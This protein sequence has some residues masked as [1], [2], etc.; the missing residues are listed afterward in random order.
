MS[1]GNVA[2]ESK[3]VSRPITEG[4][5]PKGPMPTPQSAGRRD[6]LSRDESGRLF[7]LIEGIREA[8]ENGE[9][10][11][12]VE[13]VQQQEQHSKQDFLPPQILD[14]LRK[15]SKRNPKMQSKK[16]SGCPPPSNLWNY[17]QV[18]SKLKHLTEQPPSLSGAGKDISFLYDSHYYESEKTKETVLPDSLI[19]QEYH[20]V[21]DPGVIGL[22]IR[23]G[24]FSTTLEDKE[25]LLRVFPSSYPASRQEVLLLKN[26]LDDMLRKA[27]IQDKIEVTG[28]TQMHRLLEIVKK[29]QTIYNVVFHELIRQVSVHCLE[30]G[31]L[32]STLR[33]RYADLLDRIPRQVKSLHDEVM[34]QR[35]LD[36]RLASEL[37]R[38]HEAVAKLTNELSG[39]R[40]HD[41][42]ITEQAREAQQSLESA[43]LESEKN[44]TL[45]AEYHDLY[46]M[47]RR[48]LEAQVLELVR[49]KDAWQKA[50]HDLAAK[51]AEEQGL[52]SAKRIQLCEKTWSKLAGHF[53]VVLGD[54]DTQQ[55]S[56]LQSYVQTWRELLSS[57]TQ[58]LTKQD[59]GMKERLE[60]VVQRMENWSKEISRGTESGV[61]PESIKVR[62]LWLDI[63]SWEDIMSQESERFTGDTV[64]EW[65]EKLQKISKQVEGWTETAIQLFNRHR[66]VKEDSKEESDDE[67]LANDEEMK[68]VNE[69][70]ETCLNQLRIRASGENGLARCFI[71]LIGPLETWAAKLN[72]ATSGNSL[73]DSEWR[74]LIENMDDWI[75]EIQAAI[76]KIGSPI[77]ES[78]TSLHEEEDLIKT[79]VLI[80]DV[81][82]WIS[83]TCNAIDN[84][85]GAIAE[86]VSQLHADMIR[87]MISILLCLTET[88]SE[89]ATTGSDHSEIESAIDL[90]A[91]GDVLGSRLARLTLKINKCCTD[92]LQDQLQ[93]AQGL[94][95]EDVAEMEIRDLK[96]LQSEF[97]EWK[98]TAML[99]VDELIAKSAGLPLPSTSRTNIEITDPVAVQREAEGKKEEKSIGGGGGIQVL[100]SDDNVHAVSLESVM[101][102]TTESSHSIRTPSANALASDTP[103]P[104]GRTGSSHDALLSA[105][106]SLQQQLKKA[107]GKASTAEER[108]EKVNGELKEANDK[109]QK[110]RDRETQ[111]E[112]ELKTLQQQLQLS[113]K[114]AGTPGRPSSKQSSGHASKRP[115]PTKKLSDRPMSRNSPAP[116]HA[117][118]KK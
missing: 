72:L 42:A 97:N 56:E 117:I 32:L 70:M 69:T 84:E 66:A 12:A 103:I 2:M 76:D 74:R 18:R 115:P 1:E 48:R 105:V 99:L 80:K 17:P 21:K 79:D 16:M 114:R 87:W 77:R 23:D 10:L 35:A 116:Q 36:R 3:P 11:A 43:L 59:I 44:S 20:V 94:S 49:E 89:P 33:Q 30:R 27:G 67:R 28:P 29:E 107:E 50:A 65:Q 4:E 104:V 88:E 95:N 62:Q 85:D 110:V 109:L 6:D 15:T 100:G 55:L 26:V 118:A 58:S 61:V 73:A 51:V 64:L 37:N 52:K 25:K 31:Q 112:K 9:L 7:P 86:E 39:V 5:A 108:A 98:K 57:V 93:S 54:R 68:K 41:I 45:V 53:A 81:Q 63:K 40:Q 13:A 90:K 22:E 91:S 38:F 47:Q 111:L 71:H 102:E 101:K 113:P 75:S 24:K 92:I 82:K 96:R 60:D 78:A 34:A 19:P 83:S 8:E 14:A 46:E 106:E